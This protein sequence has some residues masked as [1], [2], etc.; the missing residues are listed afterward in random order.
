[1]SCAELLL[2]PPGLRLPLRSLLAS[3]LST[4]EPF[5]IEPMLG[6]VLAWVVPFVC[7]GGLCVVSYLDGRGDGDREWVERELGCCIRGEGAMSRG[8]ILDIG[9]VA[10]GLAEFGRDSGCGGGC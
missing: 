2:L 4:D 9:G 1:M 3:V 7:A 6:I 8:S 5:I 10:E